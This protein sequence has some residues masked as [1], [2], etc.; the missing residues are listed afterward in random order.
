MILLKRMCVEKIHR[1]NPG[2]ER[3]TARCR[4]PTRYTNLQVN[5][6]ILLIIL[7]RRFYRGGG[8][9]RNKPAQNENGDSGVNFLLGCMNSLHVSRSL[10]TPQIIARSCTIAITCNRGSNQPERD[11]H[12]APVECDQRGRV[13]STSH[14]TN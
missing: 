13:P 3:T 11:D 9:V 14:Q 7:S 4:T 2:S 5:C 12:A 8:L 1:A 10:P 6:C